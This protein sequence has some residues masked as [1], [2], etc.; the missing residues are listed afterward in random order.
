[1]IVHSYYAT[2]PRSDEL[3][4]HGVLGMKWG[5]RR[6]QN[7]DGTRIGSSP[8]HT[9]QYQR[10]SASSKASSARSTSSSE[11][12]SVRS[13]IRNMSPEKKRAIKIGAAVTASLLVAYGANKVVFGGKHNATTAATKALI[14][15]GKQVA[16]TQLK[17]AKQ[18][19]VQ[20]AK[21]VPGTVWR[22]AKQ[23]AKEGIEKGAKV[24]GTGLAIYGAKKYLE[25]RY[26]KEQAN[27]IIQY[28]RQPFKKK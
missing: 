1:M 20:S 17:K 13:K 25:R 23:G 27:E 15:Q 24:A 8:R 7:Y 14:A 6:Y 2:P 21:K 12:E 11:R 16:S 26:G 3:Y 10:P 19:V 18:E 5:V 28:G 22:S 9:G 4:H